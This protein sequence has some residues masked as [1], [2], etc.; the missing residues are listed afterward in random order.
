MVILSDGREHRHPSETRI[1]V[2]LIPG[3]V[4][5]LWIKAAFAEERV[6]RDSGADQSVSKT[7]SVT[8]CGVVTSTTL[9]ENEFPAAFHA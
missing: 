2:C 7:G 8:A 1:A 6:S 5:V 9:E 4:F 3:P